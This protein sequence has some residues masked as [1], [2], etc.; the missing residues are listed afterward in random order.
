MKSPAPTPKIDVTPSLARQV[1][2]LYSIE[3]S[4][5]RFPGL[6]LSS[7]LYA[8]AELHAAQLEVERV[9]AEL[10]DMRNQLEA[11]SQALTTLAERGLA[12]A[13]VYAQG[14]EE[15]APRIA[16]VGKR[17]SSAGPTPTAPTKNEASGGK[18]RGRKPK[19]DKP[20]DLFADAEELTDDKPDNH[21]ASSV[22]VPLES[23]YC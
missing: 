8:Q 10:A 9:E 1:I 16:E 18:R 3:L 13:R 12:Y 23:T 11:R 6:D 22:T 21:A 19:A 20:E 5:V 2:D 14:D 4:D 15:L 7:L 17:K